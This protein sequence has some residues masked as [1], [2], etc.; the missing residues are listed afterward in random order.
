MSN[1]NIYCDESCHLLNDCSQV[2]GLGAIWVPREKTSQIFKDIREI[3]VKHNLSSKFEI[4]W[5]K[6]SPGKIDFYKE[7]INYFFSNSDLKFRSVLIPDKSILNHSAYAQSH[8]D[9][10]YKMYFILIKLLLSHSNSYYIYLDIKDTKGSKKWR[11]L[12]DVLCN[13]LYDFSRDIIKRIQGVHS[14]EVEILQLTDLLLGALVYTNR[15][16]YTS[17]AKM[18]L[19]DLLKLKSGFSLTQTTILGEQKFNIF[20]W[21]PSSDSRGSK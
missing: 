12:R 8:D 4:K 14:N 6:V 11:K 5:T 1:I 13:N 20:K 2:M 16:I 19:I 15:G 10:Y 3:K 7:I 9:W 21:E 18:E 17:S